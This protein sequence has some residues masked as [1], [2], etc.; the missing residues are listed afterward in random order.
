M[1]VWDKLQVNPYHY[2]TFV[3]TLNKSKVF[4]RH[5]FVVSLG[6]LVKKMSSRSFPRQFPDANEE[7]QVYL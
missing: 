4:K 1:V 2:Q 3:D 5:D 6:T 7:L